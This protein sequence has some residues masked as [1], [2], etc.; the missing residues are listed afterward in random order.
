MDINMSLKVVHIPIF[1][2]LCHVQKYMM[3]LRGESHFCFK[4]LE[5]IS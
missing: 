4:T 5:C 1:N 3:T 2:Y